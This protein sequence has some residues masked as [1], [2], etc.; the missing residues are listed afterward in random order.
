M[1]KLSLNYPLALPSFISQGWGLHP[2][3]YNSIGL[4]AHNGIDFTCPEGTPIYAAH[5]GIVW[6]SGTDTTM[7][8]TI[9]IDNVG[10]TYRTFYAHLSELKVN[11]GQYVRCGDVIGFSG[12]TGRYTTGPHLHFGLHPIKNYSD[13][14]PDN[15]YNG[16]I[17]PTPFWSGVSPLPSSKILINLKKGSTGNEVTKLQRF[18]IDKGFMQ[19]VSKYG[20]YGAL[21]ASAVLAFQ[22]KYVNLSWYERY[23][24]RGTVFGEKSRAAINNLIQ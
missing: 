9:A 14:E 6:F 1:T 12:N 5:E 3:Y 21:T 20:T 24:L 8:K 17:D 4:K 18:L 10:G 15:G 11:N 7:S 16:A 19:P 23:I 22:L 2:E 13:T